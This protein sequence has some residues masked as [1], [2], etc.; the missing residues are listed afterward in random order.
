MPPRQAAQAVAAASPD[1]DEDGY[2]TRRFRAPITRSPDPARQLPLATAL[3]MEPGKDALFIDV[4]P[5]G[6]GVR[7]PVTGIWRV[8][9][10]HSTIPG[11]EWHPETGRSPPDAV[12]WDGLEH[13]IAKARE[14]QS[15]LPVVLF[16]RTDC[17]MG[18]NAARRLASEGVDNVYWLAEGVE[19]WHDAGRELET[20]VPESIVRQPMN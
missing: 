2:R 20:A 16:C 10:S 9:S 19:G 3:T 13:A 18:W 11:S 15:D 12:L 6:T 1:F 4:L 17:W 7:D 5:V 14:K 8:A